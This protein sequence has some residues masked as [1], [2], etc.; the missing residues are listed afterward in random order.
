MSVRRIIALD[1]YV[2]VARLHSRNHGLNVIA[3]AGG[4]HCCDSRINSGRDQKAHLLAGLS[5]LIG[6]RGSN[7]IEG[8]NGDDAGLV[9]RPR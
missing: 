1:T 2:E 7:A 5:Y 4:K 9:W 6:W 3:R 8:P